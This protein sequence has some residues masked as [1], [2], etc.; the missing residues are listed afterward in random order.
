MSIRIILI[1]IAGN[2]FRT[3]T[4]N[5][6]AESTCQ[7]IFLPFVFVLEILSYIIRDTDVFY[8]LKYP[9]VHIA[10]ALLR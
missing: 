10:A 5:Y 8:I 2:R 9:I 7:E 1:V 6:D 4:R 3:E